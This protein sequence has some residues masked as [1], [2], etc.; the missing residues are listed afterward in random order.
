MGRT[1]P[2]A[3]LPLE[4]IGRF[5][6]R[7]ELRFYNALAELANVPPVLGVVGPTGFLHAFVE[8]H[9]L[10]TER[11]VPDHFFDDLERLIGEIHARRIAYV[12]ANK[13]EN[14]LLGD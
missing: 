13:P 7:R 2:F 11:P 14:I 9:P 4:L 8:G 3:G 1:E 10:S 6:C 5:L 12:D